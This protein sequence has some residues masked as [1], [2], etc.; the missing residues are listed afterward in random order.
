MFLHL[1]VSHFVHKRRGCLP[2][3]M[4]GYTPPPEQVH[5][6]AGTP[7]GQV[8]PRRYTSL[9]RYTTWA[10]TSRQ[11]Y[12]P[13]QVHPVE[14]LHLPPGQVHPSR[15]NPLDRYTPGRYTPWKDTPW[16]AEMRGPESTSAYTYKVM[17]RVQQLV[18]FVLASIG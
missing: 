6:P 12:P 18:L 17:I 2:Q 16:E 8:H 15:Y 9:G 7:P 5:P 14:Q 1:S 4:L 3:C 13:E 11:V 10:G